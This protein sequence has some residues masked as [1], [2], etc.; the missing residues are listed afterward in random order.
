MKTFLAI[1][2][3]D[4]KS[5]RQLEWAALDEATRQTRTALGIKAWHE[6]QRSHEDVIVVQ[7]GPLGKTK[8]VSPSGVADIRNELTGYV[9]VQAETHEAAARMF[10]A[11]PHF[12]VFPGE[13]VE[14]IECLPIPEAP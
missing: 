3:G 8:R 9:V 5:P 2:L 6:W 14:I 11:H 1:Y 7:G 13:S 10:E 4:A 12:T